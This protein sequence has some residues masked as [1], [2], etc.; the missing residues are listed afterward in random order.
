[1][2]QNVLIGY[3]RP[4][5]D[6]RTKDGIS[7]M[8]NRSVRLF[9]LLVPILA[10]GCSSLSG[11]SSQGQSVP[12]DSTGAMGRSEALTVGSGKTYAL[13]SEAAHAAKPG[14]IIRI[15]AGVYRDCARW[16]TSD[17]LIEGVDDGVI[18]ADKVC[19]EK[20]LFITKGNNI[21]VRNLT[22][23]SA[24]AINHNGAGIRAE[25]ANLTVE[26]SRFLD[27]EDGILA[28]D[29][30][31]STIAI[32]NSTFRGNGNCIAAC[33]H[34]IYANHIALLRVEASEFFEQHVGHHIKSRAARTEIVNNSIHDGPNG[35]ASY[36]VDLPIGGSAV[37]SGNR[38][39]KG[40]ASQ[41]KNAA[42]SIGAENDK[43]P[44]PAGPIDIDD[45]IFT[46]D[47][48]GATAFVKIYTKDP[49]SLTGNRFTGTV[50]PLDISTE[51]NK[52][53]AP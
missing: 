4:P 12:P 48:G 41:N 8:R 19:D 23:T 2:V 14:D 31:A 32:K 36:L 39:E 46:N 34:G 29:N 3:N 40:P 28:A 37:I 30:A 42:I 52:K 13:P 51:N 10:W 15:F 43:G 17:I 38:F 1:M 9:A 49:V 7:V 45:N 35:S 44:N 50:T 47:T 25:G 53:P 22:F 5:R 16:D 6:I 11:C 26:N 20:G 21:T 27:N 18:I 33:A 24:R